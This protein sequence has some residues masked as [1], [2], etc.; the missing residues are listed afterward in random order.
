MSSP[1]WSQRDLKPKWILGLCL[2]YKSRPS[3]QLKNRGIVCASGD[4]VFGETEEEKE[5][6]REQEEELGG[7]GTGARQLP[8]ALSMPCWTGE[9]HAEGS[10]LLAHVVQEAHLQ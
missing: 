5:L 3:F 7:L 4:P 1:A 8:A 10:V 9:L 2:W 6:F